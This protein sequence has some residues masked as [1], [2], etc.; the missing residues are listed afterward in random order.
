LRK[1]TEHT[2]GVKQADELGLN[3][4]I[5][6]S[7]SSADITL[8]LSM[9]NEVTMCFIKKNNNKMSYYG[10]AGQSQVAARVS[11]CLSEGR[12]VVS[13]REDS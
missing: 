4:L 7:H 2:V 3:R 11:G 1:W 5:I 10:R 12:V 8:F 13:R 9:R 6:G